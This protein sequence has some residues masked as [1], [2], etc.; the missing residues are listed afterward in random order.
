MKKQ[1]LLTAILSLFLIIGISNTA[2]AQFGKKAKQALGLG[3][4]GKNKASKAKTKG[5]GGSA[6]FSDFNNETDELGI[7]GEYFGYSDKSAV[8]LRFVKEAEGKIVDELHYFEKKGDPMMK[9]KM[10]E[11][12]YRKHQV[13]MFFYWRSASAKSYVEMIEVAPGVM[14]IITGD[15]SLNE[16]DKPI[17]LDATRTVVDL[18]AKNKADFETW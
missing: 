7:T 14:A 4:K 9:L 6:K 10:K 11:S 13:K 5:K 17:P 15:R 1:T 2:E 18:G 3:K 16:Y 8:G 12:Y